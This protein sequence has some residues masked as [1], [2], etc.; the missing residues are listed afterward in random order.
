MTGT[1]DR[2]AVLLLVLVIFA[3]KAAVCPRNAPGFRVAV[4]CDGGAVMV[5]GGAEKR[6]ASGERWRLMGNLQP[7]M[8]A[9]RLA[10]LRD[11]GSICVKTAPAFSR[12][13][14]VGVC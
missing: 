8:V 11:K 3:Q 14:G 6:R 4:R 1:I 5:M 13:V 10:V 7:E 9:A 12:F 2:F